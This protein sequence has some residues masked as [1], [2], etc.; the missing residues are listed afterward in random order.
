MYFV[1]FV[2]PIPRRWRLVFHWLPPLAWA[3]LIFWLSSVPAQRLPRLPFPQADKAVHAAF[4]AVQSLLIWQALF[5]GHRRRPLVSALLA[6]VVASLYGSL[7]E[8]HQW[9]V[10]W[11]QVDVRDWLSDTLGACVVLLHPL[12]ARRRDAPRDPARPSQRRSRVA[13]AARH[14]S[15]SRSERAGPGR[16]PET[17]RGP[18]LGTS[19]RP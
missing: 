4:F 16:V 5:F 7:D 3:G 15:G 13:T 14:W 10:P 18:C 6:G 8:L 2:V 9:Y 12:L 11:R 19:Q 17:S 1:Y